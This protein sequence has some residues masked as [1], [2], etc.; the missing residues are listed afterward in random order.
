M[1][2]S[3]LVFNNNGTN[4]GASVIEYSSRHRKTLYGPPP[5]VGD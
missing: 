1:E 3:I 5:P 4:G 2:N